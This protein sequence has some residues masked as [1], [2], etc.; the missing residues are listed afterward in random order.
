[1][2]DKSSPVSSN[3]FARKGAKFL[4]IGPKSVTLFLVQVV[5]NRPANH[6]AYAG[7]ITWELFGD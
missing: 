4:E 2:Q 1:M 3:K 7:L 6:S 5:K